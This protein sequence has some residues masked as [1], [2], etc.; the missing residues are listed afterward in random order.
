MCACSLESQPY[1][2]L[3]QKRGD[4]QGEGEHRPPL[5]CLPRPPS[6]ALHS[7]LGP[8][9]QAGCGAVGAGLEQDHKDDQWAGALLRRKAE[10]AGLV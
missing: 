1:P 2:G 5:L 7:G 8:P 10:G 4:Q 6:G 3:H 9:A